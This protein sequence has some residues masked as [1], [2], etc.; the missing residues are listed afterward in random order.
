MFVAI[1]E[2]VGN[3][4]LIPSQN[5]FHNILMELMSVTQF[6]SLKIKRHNP[7]ELKDTLNGYLCAEKRWQGNIKIPCCHN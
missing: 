3:S 4:I 1:L 7:I 2:I 6:A 5:A